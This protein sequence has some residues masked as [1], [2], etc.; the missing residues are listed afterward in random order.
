MLARWLIAAR[1]LLL[2]VGI[3]TAIASSFAARKLGFDRSIENMFATDDPLLAPYEKLK[4]VFGGNEVVVA[5]YKDVQAFAAD[6]TGFDKLKALAAKLRAVPGVRD[7]MSL[8]E[9]D[10]SFRMVLRK[11]L[12]QVED[13]HISRVLKL[14]ENYTHSVDHT[15]IAV[16]VMLVPEDQLDKET[17]ADPRRETIQQLKTII[18]KESEGVLAGEPVM[19]VDG[20]RYI[21]EDGSRLGWSSTLLLGLTIILF[22]RSLRWVLIPVL[23]VQWSLLVTRGILVTSGLRLSMVSSM[24]TAIVT[25]TGVA[26]VVHIVVHYRE[27]RAAGLSSRDALSKAISI[28]ALPVMWTCITDA[29][30]F[31]SLLTARVGPVQDFGIMMAIGSISVLFSVALLLPGL[32]LIGKFDVDP[33]RAW[34]EQTLDAALKRIVF[35]AQRYPWLI[36]V[37]TVVGIGVSLVGAGRLRVESDFTRNFRD[38]SSVVHSYRYVEDHLGGAGVWDVMVPAPKPAELK[39]GFLRKVAKLETRLRNEIPHKDRPW[40]VI[41]LAD[42]VYVGAPISLDAIPEGFFRDQAVK[43]ALSAMKASLPAFY[44]AMY[45]EDPD[46]PGQF[47]LRIMLRA[48]ERQPSDDKLEMIAAVERICREESEAFDS[49]TNRHAEAT[50]FFVLLA[51]L[52]DSM[53]AD[54][55]NTFGVAIAGIGVTMLLAFRSL[56][57]ALIALVP[58]VLPIVLVMGMMGWAGLKINMGSAMIAAVSMGLSVDS[59]IHYISSFV[60]ARGEGLNMNDALLEVQK[61]VG[62]AMFF[63]TLSLIVGFSVLCTSQFVPTIYFGALVSLSM[64]GGLLGNLIVLPALIRLVVWGV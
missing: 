19:V 3:A 40:K 24:L 17:I 31:G 12:L 52:I 44:S 10:A 20:F 47:Y 18:E 58:N 45:G 25:V 15:N 30:G 41:S 38:S 42:A 37:F 33:K 34:Q 26:C 51:N 32:T 55:W 2:G 1:W 63:S 43:T 11:R 6:G 13:S 61:T 35:G 4:R 49:Q 8:S 9:L 59:S 22:F 56:R 23:V 7:A 60:R 50:G 29:V 64:L 53:L 62:R 5:V 39:E 21:E 28:L 16:V 46:H 27:D 36:V 54:Q 14:F 57:F 48:A